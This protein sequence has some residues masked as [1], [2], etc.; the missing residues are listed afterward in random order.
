MLDHLSLALT[1]FSSNLGS[2]CF[3]PQNN[4]QDQAASVAARL[5]QRQ[6]QGLAGSFRR[7]L[8]DPFP[9]TLDLRSYEALLCLCVHM[10]ACVHVC[11]RPTTWPDSRSLFGEALG[12]P[13]SELQSGKWGFRNHCG[14]DSPSVAGGER[15]RGTRRLWARALVTPLRG[16]SIYVK[17]KK[18][19]KE[20][21]NPLYESQLKFPSP[22]SKPLK[23]HLE[24]TLISR[25]LL[26]GK[27]PACSEHAPN[28]LLPCSR[29]R[30]A[31]R[32]TRFMER[33]A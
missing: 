2:R 20:K 18:K 9:A 5:W 7:G 19:N 23:T 13:Q 33:G 4:Y 27:S 10:R 6:H 12:V 8:P 16:L 21:K 32:R 26:L 14:L 25:L 11:P 31:P 30:V 17:N 15:I 1:F 22:I 29:T 3:S 28:P 24:S